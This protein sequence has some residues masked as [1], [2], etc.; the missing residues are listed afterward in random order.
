MKQKV[1]KILW[2]PICAYFLL[3]LQWLLSYYQFCDSSLSKSS[4]TY[5]GH[6]QPPGVRKWQLIFPNLILIQIILGFS[7]KSSFIGISNN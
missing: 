4:K 5:L 2:I 6:M 3:W 7:K 1:S